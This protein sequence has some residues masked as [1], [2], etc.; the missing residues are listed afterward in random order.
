MLAANGVAILSGFIL[1]RLEKMI[2]IIIPPPSNTVTSTAA[3]TL[4]VIRTRLST[5]EIGLILSLFS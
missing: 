1:Q 5:T 3:E 4:L 2:I